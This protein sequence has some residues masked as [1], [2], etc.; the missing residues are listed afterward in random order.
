[1]SRPSIEQLA[2]LAWNGSKAD[3]DPPFHLCAQDHRE[4]LAYH[5]Q[6]VVKGGAVTTPFDRA[7]RDVLTNPAKVA[8]ELA[9]PPIEITPETTVVAVEPTIAPPEPAKPIKTKKGK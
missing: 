8:V 9:P 4:K 6:N 7:V 3:D 1:M 5:A 2:A